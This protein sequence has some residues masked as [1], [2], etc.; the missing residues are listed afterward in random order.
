M[1]ERLATNRMV[2]LAAVAILAVALAYTEASVVVY[3]R[4]VIVPIRSVHFPSAAHEP[5]PLLTVQQLSEAGEVFVRLLIVEVTREITPLVVLLAMA[6]GLRRRKGEL[7]AF[8]VFGFG[9]WDIFYYAFL[10]V[11]LGWPASLGTWDVLYLIPT[12]WV[13]PV[14]APLVISGTLV[15]TGLGILHR[16]ERP[17]VDGRPFICWFVLGLGVALV[18]TSFFL[19][20][21]EA[22]HN[23]PLDFDWPV[24][25][26]GWL[27][28]VAGLVWLLRPRGPR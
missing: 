23:V 8:F 4:E 14:W 26:A 6:W 11:L 19:R 2:R 17:H 25:L 21:R 3:L 10:K 18:L 7:V 13:A 28:G 24:F 5:L 9:L 27:L 20:T 15:L 12:A 22:F 1:A 16:D